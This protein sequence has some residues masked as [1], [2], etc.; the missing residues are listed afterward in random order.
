VTVERL[1]LYELFAGNIGTTIR[2]EW[3][4]NTANPRPFTSDTLIEPQAAPRAIPLEGAALDAA[5]VERRPTCQTWRVRGT[6]GSI[7]FP[8]LYW[9]G[10]EARVDGERVNVW[11]VE[12]SGYLALEVPS[13]EHTIVLRLGRTPVRAVAEGVSLVAA[14]A[15]L[16][17]AVV[18]VVNRRIGKSA[19]RQTAI[20][21]SP[22]VHWSLA[23]CSSSCS[24]S[25][26]RA[27]TIRATLTSQWTLTGCRTCTITLAV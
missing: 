24:C 25:G 22:F 21:H 6:G 1:Q 4:P 14:V 13:G 9:P 19:N 23:H 20:R 10:W 27:A 2:Y 5:L 3:L 26:C 11:P 7:A 17:V 16:A 12:G 18:R 8:L 15:L